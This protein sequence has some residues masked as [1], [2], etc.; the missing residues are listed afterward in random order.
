MYY[1]GWMKSNDNMEQD[2]TTLDRSD[3]RVAG[4]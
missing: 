4:Q 2:A 3:E 1:S